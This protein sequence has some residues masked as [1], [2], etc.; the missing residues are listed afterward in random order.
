MLESWGLT[1]R[2]LAVLS[3]QQRA[4][5]DPEPTCT[6]WTQSLLELAPTLFKPVT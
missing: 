5:P 3:V 1:E 4:S 6:D 2:L